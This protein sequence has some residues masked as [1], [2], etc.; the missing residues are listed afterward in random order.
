MLETHAERSG[1]SRSD[2]TMLATKPRRGRTPS[3][4]T[5]I[6]PSMAECVAWEQA[7]GAEAADDHPCLRSALAHKE[8]GNTF[9][10]AK[11][12]NDAASEYVAG[13]QEITDMGKP[14]VQ[15]AKK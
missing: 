13:L 9:F 10:E 2:A 1:M 5:K 7:A 12:Y 11:R 15:E 3:P 6:A 14:L 8:A 4:V